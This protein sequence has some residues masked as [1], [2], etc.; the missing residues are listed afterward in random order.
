M[1]QSFS[2]HLLYH[3]PEVGV[4]GGDPV[5]DLCQ[6]LLAERSLARGNSVEGFESAGFC[7]CLPYTSE[8]QFL[9]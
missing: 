2:P 6:S 5:P 8:P 9:I 1:R 4:E 3:G 7:H